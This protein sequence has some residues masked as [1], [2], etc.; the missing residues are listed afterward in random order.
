M[1]GVVSLNS[2]VDIHYRLDRFYRNGLFRTEPPIKT[3]GGKGINVARVIHS[4]GE[5]VV[6]TGFIG[7]PGGSFIERELEFL[8]IDSEFTYISSE[9][10]SCIAII[11]G[12]GGQTELLEK[13]PA[14]KTEEQERFEAAFDSLTRSCG[15]I[16]ASGSLPQGLDSG[17]YG[18]LAERARRSKLK[19]LLDTSGEALKAAIA[20]RPYLIKPN[21]DEIGQMLGK[22]IESKQQ[23]IKSLKELDGLGIDVILVSLGSEGALLLYQ[24]CIYEIAVPRICAVNTVGSGDSM[25]AGIAAGLH[26]GLAVPEAVRLG[27]ACGT[28]NA[29]SR[30]T[31]EVDRDILNKIYDEVKIIRCEARDS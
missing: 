2:S 16:C 12:E 7:G 11:D 15:I 3:P 31:A 10:R 13:G 24:S 5:T 8:G 18:K 29:L 22:S 14:I 17:Y 23:L 21:R 4:L 20:A 25:V 6:A 28:A 1:I 26:R 9:T 19:F 30:R 27:A